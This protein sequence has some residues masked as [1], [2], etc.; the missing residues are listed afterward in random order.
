MSD[1]SEFVERYSTAAIEPG[2]DGT[3]SISAPDGTC[4]AFWVPSKSDALAIKFGLQ[5]FA[6]AI[7]EKETAE[8]RIDALADRIIEV[9]KTAPSHSGGLSEYA[10][11]PI[12]VNGKPGGDNA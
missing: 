10:L 3:F 11:S 12:S 7:E 8:K 4:F 1:L 6:C 9:Q 2:E 5:M